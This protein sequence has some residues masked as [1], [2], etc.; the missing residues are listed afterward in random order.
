MKNIEINEIYTLFEEIRELVKA[1]NRNNTPVQPKIELPDLSGIDELSDKLDEAIEEI[2]KPVRT[3]YHHIFSIASSKV[4]YGMIGLCIMCLF[5]ILAVFY[6]RKE[7]TT[8]K[9]NDLKYRYVQMQ[10][11]ISP[12][13]VISLDSI[14]ENR[15]DSVKI[16]SKQV[17][18]HEKA[19]IEKAKRLEQARFK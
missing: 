9:D 12:A 4:F 2:R 15:R 18:Q 19:I 8:Y 16:I 10:G 14:F 7:I 1:G 11:E 13:G 17:E 6:Q 3:E 5:L